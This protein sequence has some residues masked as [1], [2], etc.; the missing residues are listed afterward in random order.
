MHD[1]GR[2]VEKLFEVAVLAKRAEDRGPDVNLLAGTAARAVDQF[3]GIA[4]FGSLPHLA[5]DFPAVDGR[6]PAPADLFVKRIR[7]LV[8]VDAFHIGEI[9]RIG[10]VTPRAAEEIGMEYLQRERFPAAGG[11]A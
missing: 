2:F 8:D 10:A 4:L 1:A 6:R 9:D 3:E 11:S 7:V 5:V